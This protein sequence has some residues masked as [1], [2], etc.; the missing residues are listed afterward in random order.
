MA[1]DQK[2]TDLLT[3]QWKG[4]Q[5]R[6]DSRGQ[7]AKG[8]KLEDFLKDQRQVDLARAS[9]EGKTP[10]DRAQ[11]MERIG[12]GEAPKAVDK[13][14]QP[15][16]APTPPPPATPVDKVLPPKPVEP[17]P[18]P[19]PAPTPKPS[20]KLGEIPLGPGSVGPPPVIKPFTTNTGTPAPASAPTP[21]PSGGAPP[22]LEGA[23]PG[24]GGATGSP[25]ATPAFGGG[26][27]G[28][29]ALAGLQLAAPSQLRQGLGQRNPPSMFSPLAGLR[30]VY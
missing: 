13:V 10:A 21:T 24:L 30:R 8:M 26:G 23:I 19:S 1:N 28:P 20:P 15:K 14:T 4:L 22:S 12:L 11:A 25:M 27:G 29:A 17:P 9:F 7:Q 2:I 16:P 6:S 3:Q 18:P 5:S